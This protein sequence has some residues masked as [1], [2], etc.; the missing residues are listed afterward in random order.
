MDAWGNTGEKKSFGLL[1][2]LKF[3]L[4]RLWTGSTCN[5]FVFL[6]NIA[7]VFVVKG[8]NV[9]V[10]IVMKEVID[11]IVCTPDTLVEGTT[12]WLKSGQPGC[13]STQQTYTIIG[14]YI[15]VKFLADFLG[16][17]REIPFANM[18]AVAEISIAYDVYDH[19]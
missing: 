14:V 19:V 15:L 12:F 2:M 13:P 5:K 1:G 10:P 17:V 11:S 8:M 3:T 9:F 16:Y 18:G 4:P 6:F 7:M